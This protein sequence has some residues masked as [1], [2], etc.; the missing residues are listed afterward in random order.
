MAKVENT[1]I[2]PAEDQVL[3]TESRLLFVNPNLDHI[4]EIIRQLESVDSDSVSL[5]RGS[6]TKAHSNATR[7]KRVPSRVA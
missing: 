6:E 3:M 1:A 7:Q 5:A 2:A 4:L